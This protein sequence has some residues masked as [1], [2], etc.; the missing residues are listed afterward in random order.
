MSS[1]D[2]VSCAAARKMPEEQQGSER[3]Q[4]GR[5]ERERKGMPVRKDADERRHPAAAEE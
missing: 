5:A 2:A 3:P 4:P 1:L